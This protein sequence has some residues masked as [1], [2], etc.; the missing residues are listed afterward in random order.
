[1]ATGHIRKRVGKNGSVSY[2]IV[3]ESDHDPTTGKRERI[4]RT[5]RGT[6]KQAES[7]LRKLIESLEAGLTTDASAIKLCDWMDTWFTNYL[8]NIEATTRAGYRESIRNYIAPHLG[9]IP[10]KFLKT[11]SI[12]AW[13]NMLIQ[14]GLGAKTI[15]NAYNNLNAALKKAVVLRMLAY[16]PCEGAVLPKL[17]RPKINVY[18]PA[19]I[20][21]ALKAA[22]GTS[23]FLPMALALLTGMRRGEICA[24]KWKNVDFEKKQIYV[25]ENR[26]HGEKEVVE[27]APKS[28]AGNRT[29]PMSGE[30]T[31]ILGVARMQYYIDAAE[32]GPGFRDMDYV[33]CNGNGTPYHP[34]SLTKRWRRF[35]QTSN[36]PYIR[37]HD[38]R[39]SNATVLMASGVNPKTVQ[40]LLGHSDVS[41]TVN[42][43]NPHTNKM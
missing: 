10:L 6:K 28:E 11:D 33:I 41:I 3:A 12:Q 35:L 2:Q 42:V 40:Q 36:L 1:M 20:Q 29:I 15:R 7:T 5:V 14:R 22:Y 37:F 25:C 17:K 34:D 32:Y 8:P 21:A 13:I 24:L 18:S 31:K 9:N 39:H 16:N 4:Y 30:L 27:K 19:D 38:L 23:I 43:R 26:V